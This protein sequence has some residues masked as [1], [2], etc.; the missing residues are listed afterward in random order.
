MEELR[1]FIKTAL[2]NLSQ[3]GLENLVQHLVDNVGLSTPDEC[4]FIK[5]EDISNH[6]KPIQIRRFLSFCQKSK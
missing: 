5:E 4:V 1:D 6:L 3:D 2:P